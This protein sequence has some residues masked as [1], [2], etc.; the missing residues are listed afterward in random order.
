LLA[1]LTLALV[2]F[3]VAR[4]GPLERLSGEDPQASPHDLRPIERP[5]AAETAR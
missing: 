4:A 1:V 3:G 5:G 2:G